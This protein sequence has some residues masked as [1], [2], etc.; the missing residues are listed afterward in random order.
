MFM[1]TAIAT[2][3]VYILG[4]QYWEAISKFRRLSVC[5]EGMKYQDF[6]CEYWG[7]PPNSSEINTVQM[8]D[9]SFFV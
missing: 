4:Y 8:Y 3:A 6:S 9:L 7:Y 5:I 1:S 2:D